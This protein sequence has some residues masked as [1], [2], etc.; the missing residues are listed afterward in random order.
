LPQ[1][2]YDVAPAIDSQGAWEA[3]Q[4]WLPGILESL[5]DSERFNRQNRPPAGQRGVYLFSEDG[6]H[7]YVGRTGIT[8]RTRR[9]GKEPS[10]GFRTRFD[11]HTQDG[12]PPWSAPFAMR[13]ARDHAV[14]R[15]VHVP[16][17]WW[18]AREDHPE[19][20]AMFLAA[21][22]RIADTMEMRVIA[23]DDDELGIKSLVAEAYVHAMLRTPY[24]DF[25]P[26]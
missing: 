16:A 17:D 1:V 8:A 18:R 14:R 13:L 19:V 22:R 7:L 2:P 26:S 5:L 24:N 11:Q 9:T 12:R 21:K 10:T 15:N 6:Q 3:L 20:L 25:S 4:R 23:F